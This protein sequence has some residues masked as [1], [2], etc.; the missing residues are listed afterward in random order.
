MIL[1]EIEKSITEI[2]IATFGRA[3]DKD[4][5]EYWS[6]EFKSGNMTLSEINKNFYYEQDEGKNLFENSSDDEFIENIYSNVLGRSADIDGKN[7][8][9]SQLESGTLSKDIFIKALIDGAKAETGDANDALLLKNK[10]DAALYYANNVQVNSPLASEVV[11]TVSS[12]V[13]SVNNAIG[14]MQYYDNWISEYLNASNNT[15]VSNDLWSQIDND[16]YWQDLSTSISVNNGINFWEYDDNL[17]EDV[18]H[19][20]DFDFIENSAIWNN[21]DVYNQLISGTLYSDYLNTLNSMLGTIQDNLN[22]GEN[23]NIDLL[24]NS[25]QSLDQVNDFYE[26]NYGIDIEDYLESKYG[27]NPEDILENSYKNNEDD[28]NYKQYEDYLENKYGFDFE[29]N[30]D[31]QLQQYIDLIQLVA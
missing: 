25:G 24:Q 27:F 6:S 13:Q 3:P 1:A 11:L 31:I 14:T 5:L 16:S 8:W 20:Y 15:L 18:S 29:I 30:N 2:Y 28:Y 23:I 26:D 9:L 21:Q 17:W 7:Y 10:V 12:D 19:D 22:S 4:G